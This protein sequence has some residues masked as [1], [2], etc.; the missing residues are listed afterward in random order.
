MHIHVY[1]MRIYNSQD[2]KIKLVADFHKVYK[3]T[4][5]VCVCVCVCV[6]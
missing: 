2:K 5:C 4:L 6:W 1:Y 3:E